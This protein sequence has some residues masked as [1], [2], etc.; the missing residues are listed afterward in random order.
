[1]IYSWCLQISSYFNDNFNTD[2]KTFFVFTEVYER[3]ADILKKKK[4][5]RGW[6]TISEQGQL[7]AVF[8]SYPEERTGGK[9]KT[10]PLLF[11][12]QY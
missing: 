4:I 3:E 8:I 6:F 11:F 2:V 12:L 7:W 9:K 1:M 5:P 10:F